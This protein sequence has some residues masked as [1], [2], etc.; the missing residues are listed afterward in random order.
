M[1]VK[2]ETDVVVKNQSRSSI[3]VNGV[4]YTAG[5]H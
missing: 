1:K 3:L 2:P 4:N 5:F